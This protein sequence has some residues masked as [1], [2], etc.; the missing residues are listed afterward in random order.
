MLGLGE[1][2]DVFFG[3][4]CFRLELKDGVAREALLGN[5]FKGCGSSALA[6]VAAANEQE[7]AERVCI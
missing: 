3:L 6:A 5:N 7:N 4:G 2:L 1:V